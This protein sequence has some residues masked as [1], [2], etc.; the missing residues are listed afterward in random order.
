MLL[1]SVLLTRGNKT[2][3]NSNLFPRFYRF[4]RAPFFYLSVHDAKGIHI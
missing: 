3:I 1:L 4:T 2:H